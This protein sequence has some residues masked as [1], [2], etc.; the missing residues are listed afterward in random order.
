MFRK[1]RHG[2]IIQKCH[3][4]CFQPKRNGVIVNYCNFFH[5]F[6]IRCIFRFILRIHN[7]FHRELY[8][9][10]GKRFAVMP[11]YIFFQMKRIGI[12]LFITVPAFCQTRNH[13]IVPVMI[14]QPVK[15]Q[16]IDFSMLIHGRIDAD[17]IIRSI[18][19]RV[20]RIPFCLCRFR[21][22]R[23]A[24]IRVSCCSTSCQSHDHGC[25]QQKTQ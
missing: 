18:H 2:H 23:H 4:R 15:D 25:R 10:C 11:L 24:V 20:V 7:G 14:G 8:I 17:I 22:P 19:N 16:C 13:L 12:S 1:N 3:I 9:F 5:I 21:I 6:I